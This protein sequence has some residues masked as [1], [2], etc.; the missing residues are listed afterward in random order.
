MAGVGS[1]RPV[2]DE[3]KRKFKKN[4]FLLEPINRESGIYTEN[5]LGI[6]LSEPDMY[7]VRCG[8]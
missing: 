7:G 2:F 3:L 1:T 6:N 8:A 5:F 4:Y